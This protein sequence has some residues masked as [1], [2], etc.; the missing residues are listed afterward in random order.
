MVRDEWLSNDRA[1]ARPLG[2]AKGRAYWRC[3]NCGNVED[4]RILSNRLANQPPQ[5]E[6]SLLD[7]LLAMFKKPL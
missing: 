3:L 7:R 6:P 5:D 4:G 1:M 2:P